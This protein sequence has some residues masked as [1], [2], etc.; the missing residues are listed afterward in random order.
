MRKAYIAGK[1]TGLKNYKAFFLEAQQRLE[2]EGAAVMNPAI[3]PYPGFEHKEYMHIC[4]SMIDVCNEI[5]FLPNWEKSK[6]A[7]LEMVYATQ[8]NKAIHFIQDVGRIKIVDIIDLKV[9]QDP[10]S[11]KIFVKTKLLCERLGEEAYVTKKF[12]I[13]DWEKTRVLGWFKEI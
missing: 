2:Q 6:G 7:R 9:Y 5:H 4:Y 1:I 3:L 10:Q 12:E 13:N 8:K 11:K